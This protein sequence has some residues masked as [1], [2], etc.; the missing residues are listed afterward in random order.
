MGLLF[1]T[2]CQSLAGRAKWRWEIPRVKAELKGSHIFGRVAPGQGGPETIVGRRKDPL[3]SHGPLAQEVRQK[4]MLGYPYSTTWA[5]DSR[6]TYGR[7][8]FNQGR[9]ELK[10]DGPP[11]KGRKDRRKRIKSIM[12]RGKGWKI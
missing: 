1:T 5:R 9:E 8:V 11:R 7:P 2:N 3:E 10:K 4:A 12:D 6:N